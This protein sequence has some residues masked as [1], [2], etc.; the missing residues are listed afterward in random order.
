MPFPA[1][2]IDANG[3]YWVKEP[4]KLA[5]VIQI[6]GDSVPVGNSVQVMYVYITGGMF[7]W[8]SIQRFP[9]GTKFDG[10]IKKPRWTKE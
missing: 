2:E 8:D 3:Y 6:K 5:K 7:G 4:G 1:D 9:P 10:P